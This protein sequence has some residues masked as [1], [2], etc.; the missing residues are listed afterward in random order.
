MRTVAKEQKDNY[1]KLVGMATKVHHLKLTVEDTESPIL[2]ICTVPLAAAKKVMIRWS[3]EF[4]ESTDSLDDSQQ[5]VYLA[6]LGERLLMYIRDTSGLKGFDFTD[7]YFNLS[8]QV[9]LKL[10]L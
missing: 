10:N 5:Q 1:V 4:S 8:G 6:V 7:G 3:I 9:L 2:H